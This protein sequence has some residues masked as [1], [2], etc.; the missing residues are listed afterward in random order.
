MPYYFDT[1]A[2]LPYYRQEHLSERVEALLQAAV[3]P[4]LISMLT[5]VEFLSALSRLVRTG[6]LSGEEARDIEV[7]FDTDCGSGRFQVVDVMPEHYV[8]AAGWLAARN[9][10]LR[11]VDS[12]HLAVAATN[13]AQLVTGDVTLAESANHN[14]VEHLLLEPV[15]H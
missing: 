12:L 7:A 8:Q 5:K 1:S 13:G 10:G 9:T 2:V 4:V 6:E 3:G 15:I 14:G 11:T